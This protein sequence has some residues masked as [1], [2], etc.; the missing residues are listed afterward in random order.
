MNL[1][2]AI[3]QAQAKNEQELARNAALRSPEPLDVETEKHLQHW[4]SWAKA[5]G[6][7]NVP[8]SPSAL[9]LWVRSELEAG[10]SGEQILKQ[11]RA[12][13][14][15]HDFYGL[16]DPTVCRIVQA[17]MPMQFLLPRSWARDDA[18]IWHQIPPAAQEIIVQ[19]A[20]EASKVLRRAQN[21]T[22][23]LR[24]K[25]KSLTEKEN[26]NVES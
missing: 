10:I 16:A 12:I 7:R 23:D 14:K 18:A 19:R 13:S 8:A 5:R 22:A 15:M 2:A 24:H 4:D 3:Q 11:V 26:T 20:D 9:A 25:L 21:E 17:E 1:V 6:I